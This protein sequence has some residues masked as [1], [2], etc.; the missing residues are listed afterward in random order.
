MERWPTPEDFAQASRS[1]VLRAWGNLG[2]PRRALRLHEAATAIAE[3]F[4]GRV[5]GDVD[6]L[7]E[8]P[9]I[10]DYT[11]R[12]VACFHFRAAVPV[13]DTNVRR[14][15]KRAVKGQYLAGTARKRDLEDVAALL[16]AKDAPEFSVALME[17]GA[18]MCTA[19]APRCGECPIEASCAWVAAGKPQPSE[20]EAALAKSRV[21][22]FTGTDRQVRGLVMALLRESSA[23]V[24]SAEVAQVWG[25]GEQLERAVAGLKDDGLAVEVAGGLSLPA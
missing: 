8:L 2:Y 22:K 6:K 4:D 18:L 24:S 17:L 9:G 20:V 7:L 11:A 1:D 14:V 15:Y 13:V 16:P 10:G 12:A 3:R 21:Q 19:K 23:P 5:P 25:D